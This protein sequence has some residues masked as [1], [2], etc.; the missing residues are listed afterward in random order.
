MR[1]ILVFLLSIVF[2][3]LQAQNEFQE[4]ENGL[5]YSTGAMSKLAEIVGA[6]N[7]KFRQCDLTKKFRAMPQ[8]RGYYFEIPTS[9]REELKK[10]LAANISLGDFIK[11]YD[12]SDGS[13]CLITVFEYESY[14]G[15]SMVLFDV[16]PLEREIRME[17]ADREK[18]TSTN[19]IMNLEAKKL[20][21]AV[22]LETPFSERE[23]P[24]DYARMI[25]YSECMVDTTSTIFIKN[26]T[27][28]SGWD[29][30]EE[31]T[32]GSKVDE[33]FDFVADSFGKEVP[34]YDYN[35]EWDSEAFNEYMDKDRAYRIALDKFVECELSKKEAFK[36]KLCVAYQEASTMGGSNQD[37]ENYALKYISE[38]A[39]LDLKRSRKV[40]GSCSMD[41]SPRYHAMDIAQ[42]SAES[43]SWDI[44][45][46]AHLDIMNDR[47]ERVSD[48][49]YAWAARQTYI[50]ELEEL[51]I[52]VPD[53][54]FGISLRTSN[55]AENHY[56][57]SIRRLGRAIAE[58]KDRDQFEKEIKSM[59]SDTMLDD[60]NRVLMFYLFVNLQYHKD[61]NAE[62]K[63]D[64]RPVE[65]V[66][67]SLPKYLRTLS[68]E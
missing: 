41:F 15:G 60:Y 56:Y 30:A 2:L 33:F 54:I 67:R 23:I 40:L 8:S 49:S 29:V 5:I 68:F 59:I 22:Y 12:E 52:N 64:S 51:N 55:P 1:A 31:K 25:Q 61:N 32:P 14:R 47:F 43:Y 53:L 65:K 4:Y 6:E 39:A 28:R 66:R 16:L 7:E 3:P 46:R 44:F 48:G 17:A 63:F 42:L 26:A 24:Y 37:L 35:E 34:E 13:K 20:I 57:G 10:D 62:R 21:K 38:K 36:N 11:K 50:K 58:S 18:M 45:L 9:E 19:W 27:T